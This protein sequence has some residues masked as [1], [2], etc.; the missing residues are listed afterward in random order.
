MP[1]FFYKDDSK[2]ELSKFLKDMLMRSQQFRQKL[3][4]EL[5]TVLSL[6]VNLCVFL[7][8]DG[9]KIVPLQGEEL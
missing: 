8:G 3:H 2:I 9:E 1:D 4:A 6:P 5:R 7:P